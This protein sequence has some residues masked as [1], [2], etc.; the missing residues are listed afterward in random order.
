MARMQSGD[1]FSV[2]DQ[3]TTAE[4]IRRIKKMEENYGY[5]VDNYLSVE[6]FQEYQQETA[7]TLDSLNSSRNLLMLATKNCQED[8]TTIHSFMTPLLKSRFVRFLNF[9][10]KWYIY[11]VD[12]NLYLNK[13]EYEK[14]RPDPWYVRLANHI[15]NIMQ[16]SKDEIKSEH[17]DNK[18]D[19][20]KE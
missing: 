13:P 14:F 17:D 16:P 5:I 20:G 3:M 7:E 9:F 6:K 4:S 19:S 2:F 10:G 8:I 11:G 1:E 18:S 12:G 15:R